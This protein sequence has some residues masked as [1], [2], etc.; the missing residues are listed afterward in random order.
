METRGG[1]GGYS[2]KQTDRPTGPITHPQAS[3]RIIASLD[4]HF[5]AILLTY[6]SRQCGNKVMRLTTL[7]IYLIKTK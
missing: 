6:T 1:G 3:A 5:Y 7:S 4:E 2:A